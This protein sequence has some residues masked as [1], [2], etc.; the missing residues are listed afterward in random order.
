M[1]KQARNGTF[2]FS[3]GYTLIRFDLLTMHLEMS[4]RTQVKA[5]YETII[6]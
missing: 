2:L 3:L 6:Y 1:I 4:E 5:I